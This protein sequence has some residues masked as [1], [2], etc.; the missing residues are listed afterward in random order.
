M[1]TAEQL[2]TADELET[3]VVDVPEWSRDGDCQVMIRVMDGPSMSAYQAR[4]QELQ[5]MSGATGDKDDDEARAQRQHEFRKRVMVEYCAACIVDPE[6]MELVY[7]TPA[8]IEVLAR[9]RGKG[10]Q[11]VFTA[12]AVLHRDSEDAAA[13]FPPA[14]GPILDAGSGSSTPSR[15]DSDTPTD[16]CDS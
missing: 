10:L 7:D 1:L 3:D 16:C 6:T 13:D 9:K 11:R 8:K 4:M 2:L 12:A 15:R 5:E 14:S